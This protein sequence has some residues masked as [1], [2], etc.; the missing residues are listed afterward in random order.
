[1]IRGFQYRFYPTKPQEQK[2]A[3]AFGGARYVY[4][5]GLQLRTNAWYQDQ[6]RVNYQDTSALLTELKK[7]PEHVWLNDCSSVVLQQSLRHLQSAFERFWQKMSG[8]PAFKKKHGPQSAT[9]ASSAF[10]FKNGVLKIA[11]VGILKIR[12]S[13]RFQ[14]KPTTVTIS[15]NAANQYFVSF[16]VDELLPK[17]A[18][19]KRSVGID[20]GIN[21]FATASDGSKCYAPKPLKKYLA[22]L[23]RQ[24]KALSR[25]QKGSKNRAKAK[26]AL[27]RTHVKIANIRKDFIHKFTTKIIRENQAIFVEDL[28]LRGMVRSHCLAQALSDVSIGEAM[29]QLQYKAEWYGR[30]L[31][32]VDRFY[33]SS[34][35]CHVCGWII[36]KLPLSNRH[37]LCPKCETLHDRDDNAS[38]NIQAEGQSALNSGDGVRPIR[39]QGRKGICR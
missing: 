35:R 4:N 30:T 25:K 38:K 32:K 33:P 23:K 19:A 1:V 11:K 8:Y 7:Q 24:Q 20:F 26:L 22:K 3:Q 18:K 31:Q 9:Y 2:L 10:T 36:D 5:W 12:W 39:S 6:K 17:A 16:R 37:W 29:R 14:A 28:N 21:A 15:R 13:R 27:A 34:K